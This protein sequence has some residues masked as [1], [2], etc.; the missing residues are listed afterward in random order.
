MVRLRFKKENIT[1]ENIGYRIPRDMFI[2]A[3]V[4]KSIF[5]RIMPEN[6]WYY[7]IIYYR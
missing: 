3:V 7:N 4:I 2:I 5:Y 1:V 6:L